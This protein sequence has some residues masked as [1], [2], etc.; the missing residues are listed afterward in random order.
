MPTR[1]ETLHERRQGAATPALVDGV[2]VLAAV[3]HEGG[4]ALRSLEALRRWLDGHLTRAVF[5]LPPDSVA[6]M[7]RP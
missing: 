1:A 5:A 7:K 2:P 3:E 6:G 4:P